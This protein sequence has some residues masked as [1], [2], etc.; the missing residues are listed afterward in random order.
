MATERNP[1]EPI[2]QEITN[3]VP[4]NPVPVEEDREATFEVEPD[5]GVIVDFNSTVV[6]EAEAPVKE[7]Y[8]N[9]AETL[10]EETLSEISS[11][12]YNNY[13]ADKN[14][15]QEWES[16]FERGFD[17][18]GLKIQESSEPFEGACTAV[19]PLLVESA[20]KFQSK[21]S[22]ELF[23]SAGPVKTQILGKSTQEREL[24]S[25]RV[26]NFM[27]YQ[28]TEQ[29]PE[30]FE[31][32]EKMLFHL[33]LIGSAFKKL[34][35]DANLKRPV[36][37]F[38]PIDQFYVSYYASNLRKADRYTHVIYRSPIDLAKDI[39]SG[40]YSNTELPRATNPQPT[41][42]ASKMD[43]ILGFS[44]SQ[45]SDPQY[46]LLEQHCYLELDE[47]NGEEGIALPYI[48]TIEEQS[49][50]VL[51]I[52]RN[53]ESDD[54]N[55]EKISHF[56][57]YR[58]V[59]GFGFY[60]FGLMH[61][62]GNLTMSAT[63]AMRSL[64]DAGQFANLPG[65]FKAKGVRMVGD[66]EPIS[67][68]EFKEVESTGMDLQKAIVPL[69]YKEPSSTLF[70]MLG[71]VTQAGQK[72][73]D[74]TEQIVSE[75]SSYGPVGT[76]MA[77]LE[78]SSKFFSAIHKRLHKSQRDEFW[79]LARIDYDYLP[80]EYPY[81]VP[82]ESRSIF[83]SDFDG[84]VDV[85]PVS[86]PN[87]PSN[88]HR[89]MIAQMAM[90][91]AQQSPPG[92]FNMEALNRTILNAANMPNLEEILPPKIKPQNLDPVSDIM[93]AVK[94]MP[95][96]AF[97]GQNHDA[98][99]QIKM[100]YLQDPINGGSQ[101]MQRIRPIL[102]ANIQEHMVHKYQEQM[103]GITKAALEETPTEQTPEVV[104]GAMIYAAQ[105]VLN[106]NKAAGIAKSP[107]Q[108]LV[109]LEQKKVEL[110][111][112]KLQIEAAQNA[113]EATLDAQKL[114]LEEAKLMKEVVSEGHQVTFR[115]E[116][117]DLDR[118][119]K[120]TMK[121]LELLTKVSMEDQKLKTNSDM[122]SLDMITKLA[123]E[124]QKAGTDDK[125]IRAR[126]LEK[127]ADIEKEKDIKAAELI[128]QTIREETKRKGD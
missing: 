64:I 45:D 27:N 24:Q 100:A 26:K 92:L 30:Y 70:Q 5:G 39:R 55:K 52:R 101:T 58:F 120:E 11:T 79:I 66:N 119:S 8:A 109:V 25:N 48:V 35:Y 19:H 54:P 105:Q 14:S 106:A 83:K 2:P 126:V 91:M 50:N 7:W 107:E 69:P 73:A 4:M 6:M 41:A 104:E 46:V 9:L 75:A 76:T 123:I 10:S 111:Q 40:I 127:A 61:F 37:E 53:Y 13:E 103:D 90:Q 82:Y 32:F 59:P 12:V 95:I 84:R 34:Y 23:P 29:M 71:F 77:L 42:F 86:D 110:E 49:R 114:Q 68:G 20:V 93:A 67:P 38:V 128:N 94:G 88:A 47:S 121:S 21:A 74:S 51:C 116:K 89:L 60:G 78:A 33:P 57:H 80:S 87:I 97:T 102:E 3:V 96:A 1:F 85:I 18:L 118:A 125:K 117:A 122:K 17:L 108:Q 124:K 31:E 72:F 43:T 44:P 81:D 16:M 65:G 62:L 36:A 112:Q 22:Q 115:K 98:H 56:V 28:L 113:A 99:I 15:R 63:A